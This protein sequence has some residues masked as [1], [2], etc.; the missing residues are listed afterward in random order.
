MRLER[1]IKSKIDCNKVRRPGQ[2]FEM[3]LFDI[4]DH[5]CTSKERAQRRLLQ[6]QY[7]VG[8][9]R[10]FVFKIKAPSVIAFTRPASFV[11]ELFRLLY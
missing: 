1:A 3:S 8:S 4:E 11:L 5:R 6:M 9:F 10:L 2:L 7:E